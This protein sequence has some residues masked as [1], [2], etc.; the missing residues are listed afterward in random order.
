MKSLVGIQGQ[1]KV[2]DVGL[3]GLAWPPRAQPSPAPDRV[4]IDPQFA[5][6]ALGLVAPGRPVSASCPPPSGLRS[7]SRV[8]EGPRSL[9]SNSLL[10]LGEGVNFR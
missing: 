10:S 6:R 3:H 1:G 2:K 5:R 8:P 7:P 9:R 4:A